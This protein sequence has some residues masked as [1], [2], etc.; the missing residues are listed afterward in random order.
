MLDSRLPFKEADPDHS[1]VISTSKIVMILGD[2]GTWRRQAVDEFDFDLQPTIY[3]LE[4]ERPFAQSLY[5][6]LWNHCA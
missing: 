4:K 2:R 6:G 1:K 3:K 5:N